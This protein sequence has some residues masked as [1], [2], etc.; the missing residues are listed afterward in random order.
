MNKKIF[1]KATALSLAAVTALSAFAMTVSADV[2]Y[3]IQDQTITGTAILATAS[4]SYKTVTY[5]A[6]PVVGSNGKVTVSFPSVVGNA[7]Q[8]VEETDQITYDDYG[9]YAMLSLANNVYFAS[10]TAAN[11]A[12]T[13]IK[14]AASYQNT[15]AKYTSAG[16]VV[17]GSNALAEWKKAWTDYQADYN[18][19]Y[20][21]TY[22][23]TYTAEVQNGTA[24]A[25]AVVIANTA[26]AAAAQA[27]AAPTETGFVQMTYTAVTNTSSVN[28]TTLKNK[29]GEKVN[30][31]N[32]T[33]AITAG[34]DWTINTKGSTGTTDPTTPGTS[35]N[36]WYPALS[37]YRKPTTS[38]LS[39]QG[40]NGF[41]YTSQAAADYYGDGFSGITKTSNY[42]ATA[43]ADIYFSAADGYYYASTAL[44]NTAYCYQVATGT[45]SANFGSYRAAN[46]Y[47]YPTISAAQNASYAYNR[48]TSYTT[49]ATTASARY[50]SM[51]TGK[52]YDTAAAA[53]AAAPT[54]SS[55]YVI[56]LATYTGTTTN[57]I[58]NIYDPYY[59]YYMM[60]ANGGLGT[61]TKIDP[62]APAIYGSAK[63]SGW[64]RIVS[65]VKTTPKGK[66]VTIDMN[67]STVVPDD[68]LVAAKSKGVNLK[69]VLANGATWTMKAADIKSTDTMNIDVEY[70]TKNI[71]SSL[72]SK[73]KKLNPGAVSTAQI[74]VNGS[75]DVN[76]G[77]TV[78]LSSKRAG[79]TVKA[80]I[81]T[82]SG[83]IKLVDK[84]VVNSNGS[85]TLDVKQGG[86]YLLVVID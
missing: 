40:Y 26:A 51:V 79:C 65:V 31:N 35:S 13:K 56:D 61:S 19:T 59:Y 34:A 27:L 22:N 24:A 32:L 82:S 48:S 12:L 85:V 33:G 45:Y 38:G 3:S 81:K 70:N 14:N 46:G 28:M 54:Y 77:L 42:T 29:F 18:N 23:T 71:K 49:Y 2:T 60:G 36:T 76:A 50:F 62:D 67:A 66:T 63:K 68:V 57:D 25:D 20:T 69:F 4:M 55:S 1:G 72:V 30:V 84:G 74:S 78:K 37:A 16:V 10:S 73:A 8:I 80:Y 86:D 6:S 15:Y 52:C 39:Y 11:S 21:T 75:V 7:P 17:G 64:S 83:S 9:H 5:T 41:W 47:Y 43:G 53:Q 58:Y 44:A